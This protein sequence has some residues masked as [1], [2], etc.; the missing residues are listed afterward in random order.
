MLIPQDEQSRLSFISV[1]FTLSFSL[2]LLLGAISMA[3]ANFTLGFVLF[4]LGLTLLVGNEYLVF[5]R[6][7]RKA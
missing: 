6:L 1:L 4:I 3:F 5:K 2:L 7:S